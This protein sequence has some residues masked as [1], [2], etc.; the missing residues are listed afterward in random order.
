MS[1]FGKPDQDLFESSHGTVRKCAYFGENAFRVVDAKD[2]LSVVAMVP[3]P[4]TQGYYFVVEQM[5]LE[6]L[7]QG[8]YQEV[9]QSEDQVEYV[10]I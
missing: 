4:H 2:I 10:G 7:Q 8:G 1:V 5:G 6:I 3:F 9:E